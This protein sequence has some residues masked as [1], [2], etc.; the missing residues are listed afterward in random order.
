MK[1]ICRCLAILIICFFVLPVFK[2]KAESKI[3]TAEITI[4]DS[5]Y[6]IDG[7]KLQSGSPPFIYKNRTL[8]SIEPIG[9]IFSPIGGN[10]DVPTHRVTYEFKGYKIVMYHENLIA[11]VNGKE[12][13][14]DAPAVVRVGRL[15]LPFR[16]FAETLGATVYWDPVLHKAT[17]VYEVPEN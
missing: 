2:T 4:G 8:V 5:E 9:Q 17:I 3:I 1:R 14:L 16:F 6:S 13:K 11:L 7:V 10:Y 12:V 15:F